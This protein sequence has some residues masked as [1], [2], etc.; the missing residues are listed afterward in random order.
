[1]KSW[2]RVEPTVVHKIGFRTIVSKTFVLPDGKVQTFDTIDKEDRQGAAVVALTTDNKVIIARQ[3][4][5]G[6]EMVMDELPGGFVDPGEDKVIAARRELR[7]ETGYEAG[8]LTF[9]GTARYDAYTNVQR[10]CFLATDCVLG[11]EGPK[12]GEDEFVELRLIS[13]DELI[14]NAYNGTMSDLGPVLMAYDKLQQ[15]KE[16][17]E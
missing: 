1:M 9:L 4:R 16:N 15:L 17:H 3:F 11:K 14:A 5:V 10:H 8:T 13:I 12:L 6:P 2:K 7:E